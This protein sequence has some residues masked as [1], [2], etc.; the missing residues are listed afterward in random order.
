MI[1]RVDIFTTK[2]TNRDEK[3][4]LLLFVY[5]VVHLPL[6]HPRIPVD[7]RHFRP[8]IAVQEDFNASAELLRELLIIN[9]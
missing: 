6:C 7:F 1:Y 4:F 3:Y 5:F 2:N 9:G 8:L